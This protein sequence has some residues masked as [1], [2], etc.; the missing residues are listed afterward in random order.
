M[1]NVNVQDLNNLLS[2]S[3][4]Y[5]NLNF[6]SILNIQ[7]QADIENFINGL[8]DSSANNGQISS[9]NQEK[10]NA[11]YSFAE[12]VYAMK[13][14]SD[15]D[16]DYTIYNKEIEIMK[17]NF[18][19]LGVENFLNDII[20]RANEEYNNLFDSK[21]DEYLKIIY[22]KLGIN[23]TERENFDNLYNDN[24]VLISKKLEI[25]GKL[26]KV[27]DFIEEHK[28]A[29]VNGKSITNNI[30]NIK[31]ILIDPPQLN[32]TII[33]HFNDV[34]T[35]IETKLKVDLQQ[36]YDLSKL[37]GITKFDDITLTTLGGEIGDNI[38]KTGLDNINHPMKYLLEDFEKR[39]DKDSSNWGADQKYELLI[40][41]DDDGYPT[42][43]DGK[44]YKMG[45][46][47]SLDFRDGNNYLNHLTGSLDNNGTKI[48]IGHDKGK[49][50]SPLAFQASINATV[51]SM[52][53][54]FGQYSNDP[55]NFKFN[56]KLNSLSPATCQVMFKEL[57]KY[58][59]AQ[60]AKQAQQTTSEQ[61]EYND[62]F[63][64][65]K[66][67]YIN[68]IKLNMK[69]FNDASEYTNQQGKLDKG[70][71]A[72]KVYEYLDGALQAKQQNSNGN[73]PAQLTEKEK[74]MQT[75]LQQNAQQT[76]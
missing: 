12:K 2:N 11:I 66:D 38:Y 76:P 33:E 21:Y 47:A 62:R 55:D 34:Y 74:I 71:F 28:D 58:A 29:A 4:P 46:G 27:I 16:I 36:N 69:I 7:N 40:E 73:S 56:L 30:T 48:N 6:Y 14:C 3:N 59:E 9:E 63:K 13:N 70:M 37:N 26:A 10:I 24:N 39:R 31:K 5:S 15:N 18:P 67:I 54:N 42:K 57:F 68:D 23:D 49:N 75:I 19:N 41:Q 8:D 17:Q 61:D 22:D 44:N 32:Q 72:A 64:H 1:A 60:Q 20:D 50:V 65:F 53:A 35:G 43:F 52:K 25:I 51:E 45:K